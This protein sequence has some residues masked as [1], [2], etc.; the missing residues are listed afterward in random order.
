LEGYAATGEYAPDRYLV[1]YTAMT[2]KSACVKALQDNCFLEEDIKK[3]YNKQK[4]TFWGCRFY[5]HC[6]G[7]F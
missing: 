2:F 3:Y 7:H 6:P 4:N 5:D 1:N